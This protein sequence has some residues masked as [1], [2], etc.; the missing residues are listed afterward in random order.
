MHGQT[1]H[2]QP[3]GKTLAQQHALSD[4][5]LDTPRTGQCVSVRVC[6]CE[7]ENYTFTIKFFFGWV[8]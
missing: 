3:D 2:G 7:E 6:V 8:N 5:R 4:Q 1:R